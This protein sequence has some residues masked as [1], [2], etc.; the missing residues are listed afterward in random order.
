M[1]LS[2]QDDGPACRERAVRLQRHISAALKGRL[3]ASMAS[4]RV[5]LYLNAEPRVLCLEFCLMFLC[6]D[7]L[8]TPRLTVVC[9]Q[10]C[11]LCAECSSSVSITVFAVFG[12]LHGTKQYHILRSTTIYVVLVYKE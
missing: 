12:A 5:H 11:G 4:V 1:L 10:R 6:R 3:H 8:C 7:V 9:P 2:T